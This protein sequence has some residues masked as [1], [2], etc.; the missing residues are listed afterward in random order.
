MTA[1]QR[2]DSWPRTRRP[3]PWLFAF[4]LVSVFLIP[5][6]GV[7]MKVNLPFSSDY[8]RFLIAVILG[9]WLAGV[10]L[11]K[12]AGRLRLRP[13]G[14][15]AGII[16]FF[17]IAIISI[18]LNYDRITNLGE[19]SVAEKKIFVLVGL[20]AVFAVFAVSLRVTELRAFG[21]LIVILAAITSL[22]TIYEQKTGD[23]IFYSTAESVLSPIANVDAAPTEGEKTGR[24]MIAGPSRH[25]LS[26]ASILGMAAPFAVAFAA[27]SA[28]TR[29]RLLWGALACVI[30]AGAL[31]TQ[32]RSGVVV[33]AVAILA[34]FA[35]RPKK[36]LSLIPYAL[37]AIV[38]ALVLQGGQINAITELVNGGNQA[39]TD[40]RTSDYEA[41]VPDLLTHPAIGR[42][43]GTHDS[44]RHDQYR[45]FDNEYL[46]IVY[47]VGLIGLL[48]WLL[49]VLLPV[50]QARFAMRS[51]N[52]LRGPPAL[53][54]AAGCIGFAV[55]TALYDILS[56]PQAPY[57]FVFL[58]AM[59]VSASSVEKVAPAIVVRRA[60]DL[61]RRRRR[62][63][64][65]V[66]AA[67]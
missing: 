7:H 50:Y 39:S 13:R 35:I 2:I 12:R 55:A 6:D 3:L 18:V 43:F 59:C 8:G 64:R 54:A 4:F 44:I 5:V 45:I 52:P 37:V 26:V 16:A 57:L 53:A 42:G 21:A 47:E 23:N 48:A 20:L 65:P 1:L 58:A 60:A 33:P 27:F 11:N 56:F 25:A 17:S 34:I 24:P 46:G 15:A 19:L 49:L 9:V 29:R 30:V 41:V 61:A 10:V 14:W 22:G 66:T 51:N 63:R 40:G 67:S 28:S 31:V 36:M 38:A 32:R 62:P